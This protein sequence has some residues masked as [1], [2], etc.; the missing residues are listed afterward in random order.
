V[1]AGPLADAHD[2]ALL[3]LDGVLYVGPEPVRHAAEALRAARERGLAA[4][5]VTNNASRSPSVVAAHLRDLGIDAADADVVTSAQAAARVLAEH[6]APGEPVLVVGTEAL[7][8]EVRARGLAVVDS[9]DA[10]PRAVVQGFHPGLRWDDLAEAAYALAGGA[11]WV[12]SNTDTSVPTPRGRAP[13]NGAFVA[14]LAA[15]TGLRPLVAGKPEPALHLESVERTAARR[16]LVVG[17][18]L[19]TDVLGAVRAGCPSLLVLTGVT[20]VGHLLAA[21]PGERPTHVGTDLRALLLPQPPVTAEAGG[22]VC[23]GWR[24][25]DGDGL[26]VS[27]AP[28]TRDAGAAA[29]VAVLRA[30]CAAAWARGGAPPGEATPCDE[31]ASVVLRRLLRG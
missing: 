2:V 10:G 20:D 1:S 26:V 5:Y 6:L 23:D 15:A 19:D 31:A 12:A 22:W 16:P 4:A 17:D 13:G 30:L 27:T 21:A 7:A 24:V 14:A 9:A 29:E 11:L 28:G 8:A 18:R 25:T 3:D